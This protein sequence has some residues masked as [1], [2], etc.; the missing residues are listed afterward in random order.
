ML[1]VELQRGAGTSLFAII[2]LV[3]FIVPIIIFIGYSVV[4]VHNVYVH[5][6]HFVVDCI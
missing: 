1:L 6:V 3:A 4:F 2:S 5:C